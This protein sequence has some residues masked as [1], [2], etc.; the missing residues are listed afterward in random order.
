MRKQSTVSQSL[1]FRPYFF[2]EVGNTIAFA[3]VTPGRICAAL[4]YSKSRR[5]REKGTPLLYFPR[6]IGSVSFRPR[7]CCLFGSSFL[8]PFPLDLLSKFPP[9]I[10]LDLGLPLVLPFRL[11]LPFLSQAL[12]NLRVRRH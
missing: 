11:S 1:F 7:G 5:G 2:N 3:E 8:F 6:Y 10:Q 4:L 12:L 9:H